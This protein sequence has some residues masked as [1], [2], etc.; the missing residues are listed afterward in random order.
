MEKSIAVDKAP[1]QPES[2]EVAK[3]GVGIGTTRRRLLKQAAT[4]APV[5]LTL[6]SGSALAQTSGCIRGAATGVPEPLI[7]P[8]PY[9]C[10]DSAS[11]A[12]Q[13]FAPVDVDS[14][15]SPNYYTCNGTIVTT[16]SAS[17]AVGGAGFCE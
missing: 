16:S 12:N 17:S 3:S 4:A 7:D 11:G 14:D 9:A 1:E 2:A 8:T 6:R 13:G 5:I 15:G 10:V